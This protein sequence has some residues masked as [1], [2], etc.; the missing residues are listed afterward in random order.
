MGETRSSAS[1]SCSGELASLNHRDLS[2][3][4][5]PGAWPRLKFTGKSGAH[6]LTISLETYNAIRRLPWH[7]DSLW[8]TTNDPTKAITPDGIKQAVETAFKRAGLKGAPHKLRHT[9]AVH[10]LR[11]KGNAFE[12]Q[13]ILGHASLTTTLV[14]TKL[15][16][17]ELQESLRHHSPIARRFEVLD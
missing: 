11:D 1:R 17:E 8:T 16:D 7:P 9:F 10:F 5:A 15:A 4:A 6:E 2:P 12:L 14:Y 3:P 13:R